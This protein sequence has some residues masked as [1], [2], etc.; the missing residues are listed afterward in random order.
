MT[1]G[2]EIISINNLFRINNYKFLIFSE[3]KNYF[4]IF[5]QKSLNILLGINFSNVK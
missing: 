5:K 2:E 1:P 4:K 3:K